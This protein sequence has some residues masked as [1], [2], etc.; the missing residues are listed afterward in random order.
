MRALRKLS[1]LVVVAALVA[2]LWPR[3]EP[4]VAPE[5]ELSV[6]RYRL[7]WQAEQSVDALAF[8]GR[9]L[10]ISGRAD[11][12]AV[13]QVERRGERTWIVGLEDF[14][15]HELEL[16]GEPLLPDAE[17]VRATF[18]GQRVVV[19][20]AANGLIEQ[21]RFAP[22]APPLFVHAM[23][24]LLAELQLARGAGEFSVSE[25]NQHGEG[26]VDYSVAGDRIVKRRSGYAALLAMPSPERAEVE[27]EARVTL[28][29]GRIARWSA[30]ERIDAVRAGARLKVSTRLEL[31]RVG[32]G[33]P[34]V[35]D[36]ARLSVVRRP[37]RPVLGEEARMR[38][39]RQRV[40]GLTRGQML[41]DIARF[42][43]GGRLPDHNRWLWRAVG[44]LSLDPGAAEALA[45]LI[46]RSEDSQTRALG[47]DLLTSEGS[48]RAQAALRRSLEGV[49]ADPAYGLLVQR[50]GFLDAP[51][52][53]TLEFL[54]ARIE[55]EHDLAAATALGSVV[56]K[57]GEEAS[58]ANE[59][60]V[61]MLDGR[62]DEEGTAALLRGL[63]NAGLERNLSTVE[64]YAEDERVA[65]RASA[66]IALRKTGSEGA[67]AVL[68]RLA[69]DPSEAVRGTALE[70]LR[71]VGPKA[72][73]SAALRAL[74]EAGTIPSHQL[75]EAGRLMSAE[76]RQAVY[77]R[78]DLKVEDR[79][80]LRGARPLI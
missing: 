77:A 60:L 14:A 5:P 53:E 9:A 51:T 31:E 62:E 47:L 25:A 46:I 71:E 49:E 33:L 78:P 69:G 80:T 56:G 1:P 28:K 12:A 58:E 37:G 74:V 34:S 10:S 68:R 59:R 27:A 76:D 50:L 32:A 67:R 61:E 19:E 29:D 57:L 75:V 21:M 18:E 26:R 6:D 45:A 79:N 8:E 16:A 17:T 66:A 65:V 43:P 4:T 36:V 41:A 72:A 64:A 35:V 63:G 39:L 44:L 11:L 2:M 48:P 52:A 54:A 15:R 30:E 38:G 3:P 23:Q 7:E 20:L 24:S 70:S 55:G 73:D 22:D 42:G 40:A 13:L